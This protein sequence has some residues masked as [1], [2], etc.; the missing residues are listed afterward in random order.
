MLKQ[1]LGTSQLVHSNISVD[2]ELNVP[3]KQSIDFQK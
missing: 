1:Y 3:Q 2:T